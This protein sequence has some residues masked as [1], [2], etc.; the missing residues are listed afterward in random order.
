MR[1]GG[2]PIPAADFAA[3]YQGTLIFNGGYDKEKANSAIAKGG[4]LPMASGHADLVSFGT[5]YLA[6]PDL[7]ARFRLDTAL[8][9]PDSS[10]FY[11]GD[12]KGYID[13]SFLNP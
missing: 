11:G 13:Y 9:E 8:N 1:D 4:A 6:N 12:E 3:I 7:P 10:T 2:T 5:L